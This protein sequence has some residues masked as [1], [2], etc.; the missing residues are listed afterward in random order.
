MTVSAET[1]RQRELD[2]YRIVDS[3]PEPAYDDIA[4]LASMLC[5]APVALVSLIDR[6]RQW[7]KAGVGPVAPELPRE[8]A[9]CDHAIRTPGTLFEIHDLADDARFTAN[10]LVSG[11]GGPRFY[12]GMPL[13]TPNGSAVGTVCVLD[14]QP[15]TLTASQRTALESLARITMNL[16][17]ARRRQRELERGTVLQPHA[18]PDAFA[19]YTVALFEVQQFSALVRAR[20]DRGVERLLHELDALLEPVLARGDSVNRVT[21]SGE[22][23]ALLHGDAATAAVQALQSRIEI[24]ARESG[25]VILHGVAC[26]E[27]ALE[28]PEAVYLRADAELGAA[29]DAARPSL[30]AA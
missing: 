10:P 25:L 15:R 21:G 17:E 1:Q 28:S 13:V 11:E 27:S 23:V 29:K 5:D 14:N 18:A 22:Y 12:A 24:F 7:A 4:R 19:T 30:R 20:G 9:F 16:M 2:L 3:L 26:S 8:M 6:D